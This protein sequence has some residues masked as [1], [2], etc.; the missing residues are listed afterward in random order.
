MYIVWLYG[1]TGKSHLNCDIEKSIGELL[2]LTDF[3]EV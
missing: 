1:K 2:S 3:T